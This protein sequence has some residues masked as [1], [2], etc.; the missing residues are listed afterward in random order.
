MYNIIIIFRLLNRLTIKVS[1]TVSMFIFLVMLC[2]T[3]KKYHQL[4]VTLCSLIFQKHS[5]NQ[6]ISVMHSSCILSNFPIFSFSSSF[7][8]CVNSLKSPTRSSTLFFLSGNFFFFDF[9]TEGSSKSLPVKLEF[10]SLLTASL[11]RLTRPSRL[12]H[13]VLAGWRPLA[14]LFRD[15][16]HK[17]CSSLGHFR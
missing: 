11:L 7:P 12:L 6:L 16:H 2:N 5:K 1:F 13:K 3:I 14:R 9:T 10:S 8:S 17:S 4:K 15:V